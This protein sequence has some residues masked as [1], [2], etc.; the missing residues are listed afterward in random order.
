MQWDLTNY[1]E[2]S[3]IKYSEQEVWWCSTTV[4]TKFVFP[5]ECVLIVKI[6][7]KTCVTYKPSNQQGERWKNTEEEMNEEKRPWRS[8]KERKLTC[9]LKENYITM[10]HKCTKGNAINYGCLAL[11]IHKAFLRANEV[12]ICIIL[13]GNIW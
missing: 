12:I 3:W 9:N 7:E 8:K 10:L 6:S 11:S 4:N 13:S 5:T 2:E 1:M